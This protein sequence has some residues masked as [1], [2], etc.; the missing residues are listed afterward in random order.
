MQLLLQFPKKVWETLGFRCP[1][2]TRQTLA[3]VVESHRVTTVAA[4]ESTTLRRSDLPTQQAL[5]TLRVEAVKHG[6]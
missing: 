4:L 2:L 1:P 5:V 6:E 3:L